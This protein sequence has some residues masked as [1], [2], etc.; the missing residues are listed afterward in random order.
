[1]I[2]VFL[3]SNII[4]N[5]PFMDS[6]F[7]KKLLNKIKQIN[8][9]VY[10]TDIVY[11][12]VIHNY[13][14]KLEELNSEI[15]KLQTKINKTNI[16]MSFKNIDVNVEQKKLESRFN[17]LVE[18][19]YITILSTDSN[20]LNEVIERAIRKI[21]P[22]SDNKEEFRDCL[23]W[24]TYVKKAELDELENC[25]FIT[26]N[27]SDFFDKDKKSL[28]PDLFKDSKR[29]KIY[30][31]LIDFF[32]SE[33]R[34]F[35]LGNFKKIKENFTFKFG[36]LYSYD[37]I[38]KFEYELKEY[39]NKNNNLLSKY[40]FDLEEP[41]DIKFED[42]TIRDENIISTDLNIE[43]KTI[44]ITGELNIYLEASINKVNEMIYNVMNIKAKFYCVK[45]IE[46][47]QNKDEYLLKDA[48]LEFNIE[49]LDCTKLSSD[50]I[51]DYM[52]EKYYYDESLVEAER[53]DALE[54]YYLH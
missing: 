39:I 13:I 8:G 42:Y 36:D 27:V 24:L 40:I 11:K 51:D 19:N 45:E 53:M 10:I 1:M 22:F 31:E 3:D 29:F 14:R 37:M 18:N 12:E 38:E 50:D 44:D 25:F 15:D 26:N 47:N 54:N 48:F 7:N 4:Y 35:D 2:N 32:N 43:N 34:L 9:Y 30:K 33:Q 28:H 46:I 20:L 6:G 49:G 21:K 52:Y 23:I 5:N 17:E 16:E 41:T